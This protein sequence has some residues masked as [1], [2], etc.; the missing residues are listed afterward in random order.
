MCSMWYTEFE[1][2]KTN[3]PCYQN[4]K[5]SINYRRRDNSVTRAYTKFIIK[6]TLEQ[7]NK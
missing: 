7:K 5:P 4:G 2:F 3:I 6:P 1:Y